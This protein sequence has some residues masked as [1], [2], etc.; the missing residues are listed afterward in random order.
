VQAHLG[1][2][3]DAGAIRPVVG[4]TVAFEELPRALEDMEARST[5]GRIVV[6]R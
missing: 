4:R 6:T 3:L 2:L 5:T 1:E